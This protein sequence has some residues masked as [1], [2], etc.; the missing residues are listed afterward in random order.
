M[1]KE[2]KTITHISVLECGT[3]RDREGDGLQG[4]GFLKLENENSAE[5]P[6]V[7]GTS[8]M[9]GGRPPCL[10]EICGSV[11][12]SLSAPKPCHLLQEV[13]LDCTQTAA[14]KSPPF[15]HTQA[16]SSP[17]LTQAFL[18]RAYLNL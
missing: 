13:S 8:Q 15:P 5:T 1:T 6:W 14:V 2:G 10:G 16:L 18:H 11:S 4:R 7:S 9:R 3:G 17:H 12:A